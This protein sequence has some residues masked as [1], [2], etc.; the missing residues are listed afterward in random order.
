MNS[1]FCRYMDMFLM[2]NKVKLFY[3]FKEFKK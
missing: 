1:Y 2:K 3:P